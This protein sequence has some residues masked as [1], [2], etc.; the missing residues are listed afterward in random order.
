MIRR[1]DIQDFDRIMEMMINFAN[2]SPYKPHHNPQYND[3]YVRNLLVGLTQN[4]VIVLGEQ[5]S[6]IEGMLIGAITPDPWLPHVKTMREIAWWVEPCARNSTLGYKLLKKYIEYGEKMQDAGVI[7]GF[8][9]TCMEISPDFN[10]E[11]RG[12][13]PIERNYLYEGVN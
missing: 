3:Q 5:D 2:S 12:W 8:T 13:K 11:K 9:L 7:D 1:A 4:G 6:Q 10:L